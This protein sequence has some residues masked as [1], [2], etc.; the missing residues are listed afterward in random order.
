VNI[1]HRVGC[2]NNRAEIKPA[3]VPQSVAGCLGETPLVQSTLERELAACKAQLADTQDSKSRIA[4]HYSEAASNFATA[5]KRAEKAE[6]ALAEAQARH[7]ITEGQ[8][9]DAEAALAHAREAL[10]TSIPSDVAG[11]RTRAHP[12]HQRISTRM[13]T[14][15]PTRKPV[16]LSRLQ[17]IAFWEA[18]FKLERADQEKHF[19]L[20]TNRSV[21]WET[22][23]TL[24]PID[25]KLHKLGARF[26]QCF[27]QS[28]LT[29][30]KKIFTRIQAL[31]AKENEK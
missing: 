30:A 14:M 2:K 18:F 22:C 10:R 24:G 8:R 23:A 26:Y 5:L 7:N 11:A 31:V 3:G 28:E 13:N 16:P 27:E 25:H 29:K 6:A 15:T 21:A 20:A 9:Q 19:P 17:G 4:R 1:C 12:R